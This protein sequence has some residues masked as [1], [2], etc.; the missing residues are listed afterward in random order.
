MVHLWEIDHPYYCEQGNYYARPGE[1][2]E[3]YGSWAE[4]FEEEGALDADLNL[5]FRWDWHRPD[6][7]DVESG[8]AEP[9]D[10]LHLFYVSQR[11]AVLRSVAVRV[12]EDDEPAVREW[13]TGKAAHI[14]R[15]WAPF[16]LVSAPPG[17]A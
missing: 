8:D 11:K 16:M 3:D 7:A 1:A 5:L 4:F 6:P 10:E 13:L 9:G 12:T 2:H 14:T 17:P 15:L